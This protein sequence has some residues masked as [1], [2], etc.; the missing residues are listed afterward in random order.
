GPPP[1]HTGVRTAAWSPDGQFFVT[2][3]ADRSVRLWDAATGAARGPGFCQPEAVTDLAV[4]PDGRTILTVGQKTDPPGEEQGT[5]RFWDVASGDC[6]GEPL[7]HPGTM[8]AAAFSP[9][10]RTVVTAGDDRF[11]RWDLA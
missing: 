3:G 10:G 6:L 11:Q 1:T 2:G 7:S 4:S 8:F 9:D 5:A